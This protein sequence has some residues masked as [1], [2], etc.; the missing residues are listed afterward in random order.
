M[1]LFRNGRGAGCFRKTISHAHGQ[2]RSDSDYPRPLTNLME[3]STVHFPS[4]TI[5]FS[6]KTLQ[7]N[8]P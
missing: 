6:L 4:P 8:L 2:I 3:I 1:V 7:T 5:H